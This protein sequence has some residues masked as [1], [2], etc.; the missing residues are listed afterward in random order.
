MRRVNREWIEKSSRKL[1]DNL[2][3]F[4]QGDRHDYDYGLLTRQEKKANVKMKH[5]I[6][7]DVDIEAA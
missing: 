1:A 2:A 6:E 5:D 7:F 4:W 3:A